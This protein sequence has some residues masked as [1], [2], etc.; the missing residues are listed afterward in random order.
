MNILIGLAIMF[1][2][3]LLLWKSEWLI[4]NVGRMDFF[5][6]YLRTIGGTRMG[7]KLIGITAMLIGMMMATNLFGGFMSFVLSPLIKA[8]QGTVPGAAEIVDE[9]VPVDYIEE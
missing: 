6:S 5:E 1:S 2:G 7:Y 9:E 3:F 4:N 8:Q